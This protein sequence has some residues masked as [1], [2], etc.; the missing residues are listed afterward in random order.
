MRPRV[1]TR[2]NIYAVVYDE[3]GILA[4]MRPRVETRGNPYHPAPGP[5]YK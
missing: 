3:C 1:E 4:S 5:P 2:G